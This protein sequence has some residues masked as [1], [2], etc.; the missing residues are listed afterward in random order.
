MNRRLTGR[1]GTITDRA[2]VRSALRAIRSW[3][4]GAAADF[5]P[6]LKS[7]AE[8]GERVKKTEIVERVAGEAGI[9]KQAAQDRALWQRM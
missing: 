6:C 2:S 5:G 8:T 9:T 4:N 1:R 7:S 3:R